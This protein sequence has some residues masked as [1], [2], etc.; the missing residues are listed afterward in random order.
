[1][2]LKFKRIYVR[3]YRDSGQVFAYAEHDKG[4]TEGRMRYEGT[5]QCGYLP[6]FGLHMHALFAA[7][8]RQGLKLERETLED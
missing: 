7:A 1:M 3:R 5:P 6:A 2:T 8:K 4:W